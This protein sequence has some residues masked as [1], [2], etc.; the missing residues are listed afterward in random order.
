[1][2]DQFIDPLSLDLFLARLFQKFLIW[3]SFPLKFAYISIFL[4]IIFQFP[5]TNIL[6]YHFSSQVWLLTDLFFP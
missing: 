3:F 5:P 1:M 6:S 4:M 2:D